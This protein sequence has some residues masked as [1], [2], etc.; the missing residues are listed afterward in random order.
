MKKIFGLIV[1]VATMSSCGSKLVDPLVSCEKYAVKFSEAA[2]AFSMDFKSKTKCE[3]F[4]SSA[5]DYIK[6]CPSL[7]AAE[8]KQANDSIK[9]IN[10]N[11]L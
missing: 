6:G 2:T 7:S 11:G 3:A 10:C 9:D 1:I 5:Q 4:K 8:V